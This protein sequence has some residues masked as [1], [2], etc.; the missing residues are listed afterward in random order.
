MIAYFTMKLKKLL[1]NLLILLEF[2]PVDLTPEAYIICISIKERGRRMIDGIECSELVGRPSIKLFV[3]GQKVAEG[4][5]VPFLLYAFEQKG[6]PAPEIIGEVLETHQ[7]LW[8]E[9]VASL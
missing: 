9:V 7:S 3:K 1:A 8:Q 5:T 6:G 2:F 4:C